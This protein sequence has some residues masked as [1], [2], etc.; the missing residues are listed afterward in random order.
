MI[1]VAQWIMNALKEIMQEITLLG[2]WRA[3]FYEHALFYGG[4]SLRILYGLNRFSEV[5]DFSW[6]VY[7]VG[8]GQ[9]RQSA[10]YIRGYWHGIRN[11]G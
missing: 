7:G 11:S 9:W 4:S 2:L 10:A 1:V 5:L 6:L 8:K 3:K